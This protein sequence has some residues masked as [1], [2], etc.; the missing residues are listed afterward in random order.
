MREK[1]RVMRLMLLFSTILL[2]MK[3]MAWW[4]T[5]SNAIL[6]DARESIVNVIAGT[7]A[8]FSIIYASHPRDDDHPY[9]HGKIEFISAGF[10]GALIPLAGGNILYKSIREFQLPHALPSVGSGSLGWHWYRACAV[11]LWENIS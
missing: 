9:E 11:I 4:L 2:V 6:I 5:H 3:F 10:E 7:F 8:L 1:I